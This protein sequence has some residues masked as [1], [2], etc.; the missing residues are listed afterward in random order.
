MID[1]A[2]IVR[3]LCKLPTCES[4]DC[5]KS[6]ELRSILVLPEYVLVIEEV[7]EKVK[8]ECLEID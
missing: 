3:R 8:T 6:Q 1:V 5:K 4:I 2:S 7:G